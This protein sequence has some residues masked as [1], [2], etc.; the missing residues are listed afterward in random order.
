MNS[1][2]IE[3]DQLGQAIITLIFFGIIV[4][5]ILFIIGLVQLRVNKKR[6]KTILIIATVYSVISFGVCGGFGF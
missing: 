3:S 6:A 1:L 4:P 2:I 5:L